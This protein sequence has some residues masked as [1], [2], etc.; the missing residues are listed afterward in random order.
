M[1]RATASRNGKIHY[2]VVGAG[3]PVAMIAGM[4]GAA[5]YWKPQIGP[6]SERYRLVLHDQRGSGG[7]S[8]D[9]IA[10]DVKLMGDDLLAVLDD[11]DIEKVHCVGHAVGAVIAQEVALRHPERIASIVMVGAWAKVDP[12][13]RRVFEIRKDLLKHC[14]RMAYVRAMPLFLNTP[15]WVSRNMAEIEKG[16]A[17]FADHLPPDDILLSRIDA[18]CA[19]EAGEALAKLRCPVLV[20]SAIDD[21]LV[22]IHC[23][24]ELAGLMPHAETHYFATGGHSISQ[25]DPE[26]F[27]SV[28]LG[29]LDKVTAR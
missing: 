9:R 24:H 29:F 10:Y 11:L 20:C 15:E 28:V 23:A 5:S 14:G 21:H 7:S 3:A 4:G 12:Y 6:F 8:K 27:N 13:F 17:A 26:H 19:Y 25:T 2:E 16:E 22:P 1:P 18:F